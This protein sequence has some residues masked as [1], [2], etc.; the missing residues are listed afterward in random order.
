M[1]PNCVQ[2]VKISINASAYAC[3]KQN[4]LYRHKAIPKIATAQT[5]SLTSTF[6]DAKK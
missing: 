4:S 3:Y 5:F 1:D 6:N 2:I